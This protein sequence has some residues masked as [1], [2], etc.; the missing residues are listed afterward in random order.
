MWL[1]IDEMQR[2]IVNDDNYLFKVIKCSQDDGVT[3]FQQAN[4]SKKFQHQCF[5]SQF[6]VDQAQGD[7]VDGLLVLDDHVEPELVVHDGSQAHDANV[8]I[9]CRITKFTVFVPFLRLAKFISP[10]FVF[11][12]F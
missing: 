7:G 12:R 10:Q 9:I 4:C 11:V 8:N 1:W 3:I 5:R 6:F 2:Y